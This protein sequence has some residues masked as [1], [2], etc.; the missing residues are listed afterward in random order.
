MK[1][2]L[3]IAAISWWCGFKVSSNFYMAFKYYIDVSNT[4]YS[5]RD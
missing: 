2:D 3:R 4:K 1:R 5:H